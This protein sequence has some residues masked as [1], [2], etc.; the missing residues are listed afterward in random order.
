MESWVFQ[1]ISK[2]AIL[3]FSSPFVRDFQGHNRTPGPVRPVPSRGEGHFREHPLFDLGVGNDYIYRGTTSFYG[4]HTGEELA[5]SPDQQELYGKQAV[6]DLFPEYYLLKVNQFDDVA[7]TTLDEWIYFL[8]HE[9]IK[10]EFKA[11]GLKQAREKLDI[12]KLPEE[13]RQAFER[14]VDDLHYQASMLAGYP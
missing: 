5:L 1:Q 10:D 6:P 14:Y 13:E 12:L 3:S 11:Q 7:K 9:E 2:P 4:I 8:K